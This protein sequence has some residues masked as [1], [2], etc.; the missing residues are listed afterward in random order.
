MKLKIYS[1]IHQG[2]R[3]LHGCPFE[4]EEDSE[5]GEGVGREKV[6]AR[7]WIARQGQVALQEKSLVRREI[8]HLLYRWADSVGELKERLL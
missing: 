2:R 4:G 3:G 5:T 6:S 1:K 7:G 8:A